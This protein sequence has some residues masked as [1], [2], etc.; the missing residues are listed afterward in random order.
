MFSTMNSKKSALLA[1]KLLLG[2]FILGFATANAQDPVAYDAASQTGNQAWTGNLGMDF[3]VNTGH[4][5]H[6]TAL[7]AFKDNSATGFSGTIT[8]GI[9]NRVSMAQIGSSVTLTGTAGFAN[10]GDRFVTLTTPISLGVGSYSVVAVGYGHGDLNGNI[11]CFGITTSQCNGANITEPTENTNSGAITFVD[12]GRFDT[13]TT[14]DYPGSTLSGTTDSNPFLAGT[15][16]YSEIA[17]TFTKSFSPNPAF[18][19]QVTTLT[20]TIQNPDSN[21]LTGVHFTD[22]LPGPVV[23][24]SPN[25]VTD[26]GNCDTYSTTAA[27]GTNSINV[28]NAKIPGNSTCTISVNVT[29]PVEGTSVGDWLNTSSK[30]SSNEAPQGGPAQACLSV[31]ANNYLAA[32]WWYWYVFPT[33]GPN[34]C[35]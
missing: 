15:F 29:T 34:Q 28:S 16:I 35:T 7:G 10:N 20:F 8:V 21:Q 18:V 22:T 1:G 5:I 13:N 17:P 24:A 3:N 26:N 30:V 19:G 11:T 9:F 32:G 33:S 23:I 6:I 4:T 27:P 14:L 12:H 25:G 2:V 31:N